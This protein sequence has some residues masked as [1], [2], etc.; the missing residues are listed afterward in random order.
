MTVT[1]TRTQ[2]VRTTESHARSFGS[3]GGFLVKLLLM[4]VVNGFGILAI[5][6]AINAKSWIVAGVAIALLVAANVVY[7][8]R[9]ALPLKYLFPGLVFLAVFQV[10][11]MGYTAYVAFTNYGTG[12]AGSMQHAVDAALIQDE[13]RVADAPTFPLAVVKQG[14]VVGFAI[15]DGDRVKV[16]TEA[17]PMA[18]VDGAELADNGIPSTVPGWEVV[19]KA[20]LYADKTLQDKVLSLRVPYSDD[21]TQG[22]IRTREGTRA[23]TYKSSLVWDSA[24]KTLTN[25]D[26]GVVYKADLERGNFVADDGTALPTGWSVNVGLRNF[27]RAFTEGG[28]VKPL[29]QVTLWT[30]AFALLSVIASFAVG[31]LFAIL[32]NDE[33]LRGR[34]LIRTLLILPYA[35]PAFMSALLWRGMLNP[36]FGIVNQMFFLGHDIGW[37]QSPML[38]RAALIFVNVWLSYPYWFLVCTGA[39]Q[40]LPGDVLEAATLDGAG[41]WQRFKSVVLPL[42]LVSTAPLAIS[43]FAFSFNNFTIIYMLNEGGPAFPGNANRL[44]ATDILISAIYKISGVAGGVADYGLASAL[45]II[46][47]V[48]IGLISGLAFRQTRKLEEF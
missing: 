22:S 27:E 20:Q 15:V 35:F 3:I 42:L 21:A 41:R 30:F 19:Q 17:E 31:L 5:L 14:D 7:F 46:V 10:F 9:R 40:S 12:H 39:L 2:P 29:L 34:K 45:S 32:F 38:A 13:R 1:T 8:M 37:L 16:G 11:T 43:S 6:S 36:E 47:F 23:T 25:T 26:T 18:P 44:G 4:A 48:V 33:R 24:A 28:L